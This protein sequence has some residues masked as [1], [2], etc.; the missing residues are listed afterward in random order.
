MMRMHD[1]WCTG[2]RVAAVTCLL[3]AGACAP[4]SS[5]PPDTLRSDAWH[6]FEGIWTA[7]G[8]RRVIP[9][10]PDRHASVGT[11]E[12]TLLLAGDARPGV[13]F[14][15]EALVFNDSATALTGR[16]VWTDERGDQLYSELKGQGTE[17]GN[18]IVGTFVGGS[19]R[20][21]GATGGYEFSWQFVLES[22]DG[23]VQG[24]SQGFRGRVRGGAPGV[25]PP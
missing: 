19:G 25:A 4:P 17:K 20:Y 7:T 13:G 9:L 18:R 24:Q 12:G 6:E 14:R 15:A 16:A 5:A 23:Q 21:A 3:A 8:T 2:W 22:D 10:G 11:F 1:I